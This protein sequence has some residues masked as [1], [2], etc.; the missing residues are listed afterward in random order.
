MKLHRRRFLACFV[1]AVTAS[2]QTSSFEAA[3]IKRSTDTDNESFL[4]QDPSGNLTGHNTTLRALLR[5]AFGVR[6][7]QLISGPAWMNTERYEVLAKPSVRAKTSAEFREM[8]QALV[9]ERFGLQI[10]RETRQLPVYMLTV[11][12]DGPRLTEWKDGVGPSCGYLAGNLTCTKI[13]MPVLADALSRRLGRSVAD[14]TELTGTYNLKLSWT[15]DETQ[16][17]GPAESG[18]ARVSDN[19]GPSL[20]SAIQ[21]QLGLK[22]ESAKSAT[23]VL[24]ID[25]AAK[26]SEN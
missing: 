22:L 23:E 12:K 8:V 16:V 3:S 21:A 25:K 18:Q 9:T 24:V 4:M 7:H 11:A 26:P 19:A 17:P 15:P 5:M 10:H 13:T 2:G 14:K 6:D 1:I 20:F